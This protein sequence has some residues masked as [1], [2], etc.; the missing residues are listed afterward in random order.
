MSM[1]LSEFVF[2]IVC[3]MND[4]KFLFPVHPEEEKKRLDHCLDCKHY[5][6]ENQ[7]CILCNCY[8]PNKVKHL[9]EECPIEKWGRNVESWNET[10]YD[11]F[12]NKVI[13]KYPEAEQ[14]KNL[15]N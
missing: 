13:E 11:L 1:E 8:V 14:W 15:H 7:G 4:A 6:A 2:H 3:E 12:V 9:Y 5:H 10:Y